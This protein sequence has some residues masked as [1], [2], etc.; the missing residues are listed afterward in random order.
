MMRLCFNF[1]VCVYAQRDGNR[2]CSVRGQFRVIALIVRAADFVAH[3]HTKRPH[4]HCPAWIAKLPVAGPNESRRAGCRWHVRPIVGPVK[5]TRRTALI[6]I[7]PPNKFSA[8]LAGTNSRGISVELNLHP[9]SLVPGTFFSYN[10]LILKKY[11]LKWH[12]SLNFDSPY[13]H[14]SL[15]KINFERKKWASF[16]DDRWQGYL[17]MTHILWYVYFEEIYLIY[18]LRHHQIIKSF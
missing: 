15:N 13:S 10:V 4:A 1:S 9:N 6:C 16:Y 18:V 14:I 12:D 7:R 17:S 8:K 3:S 2:A 11:N 5:R